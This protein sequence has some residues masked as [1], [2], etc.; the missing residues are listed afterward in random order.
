M[1]AGIFKPHHFA[2]GRFRYAYKGHYTAPPHKAGKE[3]VV[4]K[5]KNT[6]TW[7]PTDWIETQQIVKI[8]KQLAVNFNQYSKTSK[9]VTFVDVDVIQVTNTGSSTRCGL[10]EWVTVE[11][12]IP[13]DYIKW[14]NNYGAIDPRSTS[15]PAF[16][17]WSWAHT[18]GETMIA[19]LQ[20][21]RNDV[22][23]NNFY[24]PLN[25]F[26]VLTDPCLLS[27]TYGG[28]YGCTDTGIEGM[29]MFFLNHTCNDF[30]KSIPRPSL[31]D[32][33]QYMLNTA[34]GIQRNIGT[35]TAYSHE[36]TFSNELRDYLIP[37][38]REIARTANV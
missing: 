33:P 17:H 36:I 38:F 23:P 5:M 28:K 7:N 11:D 24:V 29:A 15:M 35:S 26:Y 32:V 31:G 22:P 27:N 13:G 14:C 2:E 1:A 37:K 21:V 34:L 12:Y 8:S 19:D 25:G 30:C 3:C 18:K 20:G 6:Y 16:V 10:H 9:P 4:K